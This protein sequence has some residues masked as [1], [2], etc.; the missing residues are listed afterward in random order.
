MLF[1]TLLICNG[2]KCFGVFVKVLFM[3]AFNDDVSGL[4]HVHWYMCDF[5]VF[6]CVSVFVVVLAREWSVVDPMD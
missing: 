6:I 1:F 2:R 3:V 5:Y 4:V